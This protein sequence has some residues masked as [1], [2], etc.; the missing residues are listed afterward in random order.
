[1]IGQFNLY[2]FYQKYRKDAIILILTA[3][4]I[5]LLSPRSCDSEVA[6]ASSSELTKDLS[7][8]VK[9]WKDKYDKEHA[10]VEDIT[11]QKEQFEAEVRNLSK[12]LNTKPS[13]ISK[14]T[15]IVTKG[16]LSGKLT[17][18][19]TIPIDTTKKSIDPIKGPLV[20]STTF[21]YQDLPWVDIKG[22]VGRKDSIHLAINDTLKVSNYSKKKWLFAR[23]RYF[24]D[25]SNT[26]PHISVKGVRTL[27][28][29]I[30]EPN[31]VITPSATFGYGLTNPY[32]QVVFGLTVIYYPF[33]IKF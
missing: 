28:K 32:P 26:N 17:T 13:S 6:I 11:L 29:E 7:K 25:V 2:G 12:I 15:T 16:Q 5:F 10:T 4:I 9:F 18:H 19:T 27:G 21:E 20:Q 8:D 24:T 3:V 1:M 31:F 30:K 14:V 23:K 22:E 33:S